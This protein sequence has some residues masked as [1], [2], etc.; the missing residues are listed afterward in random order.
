MFVILFLVTIVGQP[1]APLTTK[2][3]WPTIEACEQDLAAEAQ[4]LVGYLKGNNF[5]HQAEIEASC[6]E[7]PQL[8][9]DGSI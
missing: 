1:P 2:K 8:K 7:K 6:I 9:D 4:K 5:P 3:T